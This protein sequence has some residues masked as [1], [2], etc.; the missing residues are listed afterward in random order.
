MSHQGPVLFLE[1][2]LKAQNSTEVGGW[3]KT[4]AETETVAGQGGD[5]ER[6]GLDRRL[7]AV[8]G[9]LKAAGQLT[10]KG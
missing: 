4:G 5:G 3:G 1:T 10:V 6:L 8:R 2:L 7:G 9:S